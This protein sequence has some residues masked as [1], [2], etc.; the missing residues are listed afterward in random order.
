M[1][2]VMTVMVILVM[3]LMKSTT[4]L[5][6]KSSTGVIFPS[7]ILF[8]LIISKMKVRHEIL[9]IETTETSTEIP[10]A[11]TEV[12][13]PDSESLTL[14]EPSMAEWAAAPEIVGFWV[15]AKHI[16]LFSLFN[17]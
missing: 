4:E 8:L 9:E 3:L 12:S 2:L 11:S 1:T 14:V 17:V 13:H 7:F 6:S 10:E 5:V 16:V 15:S